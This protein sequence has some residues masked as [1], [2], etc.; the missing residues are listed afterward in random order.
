VIQIKNQK[1]NEK[2][3]RKSMIIYEK[4]NKIKK[5]ESEKRKR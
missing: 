3:N 4:K 2:E 5:C 1:K